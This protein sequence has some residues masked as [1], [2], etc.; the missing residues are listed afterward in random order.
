MEKKLGS[1]ETGKLADMIVIENNIF[2]EKPADIHNNR[3]LITV[4]DGN[5]VY[6]AK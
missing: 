6:Q 2:K 5:I 4:M 1:I 3:V